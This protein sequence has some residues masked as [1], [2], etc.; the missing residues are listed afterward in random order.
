MMVPSSEYAKHYC[1]LA[2]K[3]QLMSL[4]RVAFRPFLRRGTASVVHGWRLLLAKVWT[5]SAEAMVGVLS[6]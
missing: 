1:T 6:V 5:A 4:E 3:G 2:V